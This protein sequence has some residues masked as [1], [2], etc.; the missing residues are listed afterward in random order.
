MWAGLLLLACRGNPVLPPPDI[1]VVVLNSV[2]ADRLATY[3][4]HRDNS[5][6]LSAI[7]AS[8]VL[9]AEAW[10]PSPWTWPSHASLFT[11]EPPWIH[12]AHRGADPD[13]GLALPGMPR[14]LPLRTDLPTLA[15]RLGGAGY[16]SASVSTN[17]LLQPALGLTRGF[18]LAETFDSDRETLAKA[19]SILQKNKGAPLFLLVNFMSAHT[20]HRVLDTVPWSA[21]HRE[22]LSPGGTAS[23]LGLEQDGQLGVF[24]H[25]VD[26]AAELPIDVALAAGSTSLTAGELELL[27]DLY[28]G[29]LVRL[30]HSLKALVE[31]WNARGTNGVIV[32]TS[33]HGESLGE[34]NLL[35]HGTTVWPEML[36]VPLVVAAPGRWEGGQAVKQPVQLEEVFDAILAFA[37]LAPEAA[38]PLH[39]ARLG[40]PRQAPILAAVRPPPYWGRNV[41]PAF[42]G[43]WTLFKDGPWTLVTQGDGARQLFHASDPAMTRDRSTADPAVLER[44]AQ[45]AETAFTESPTTAT[46]PIPLEE[47]VV[48]SLRALGYVSH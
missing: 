42:A 10:A 9:F 40:K 22:A 23:R 20:P 34:R 18:G 45:S 36:R 46:G 21:A 38:S 19:Q 29:E 28:D 2:R 44:L 43:R 5:Y 7:A 26:A 32:V 39:E 31:T 1:L 15:E 8:G 25:N 4:H 14:M 37:G 3:G 35:G 12:G 30:D 13:A 16:G 48:E 47:D 33:D 11:G 24:I 6:Q 27:R 41:G 17:L